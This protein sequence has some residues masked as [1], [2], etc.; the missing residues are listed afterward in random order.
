LLHDKAQE[1]GNPIKSARFL[2]AFAK[3]SVFFI[4]AIATALLLSSWRRL[5]ARTR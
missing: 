3:P 5:S 4:V 2:D 1:S